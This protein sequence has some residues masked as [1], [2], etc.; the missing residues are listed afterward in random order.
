MIYLDLTVLCNREK[1]AENAYFL[2]F[3]IALYLPF[4]F[5]VNCS[6]IYCFDPWEHTHPLPITTSIFSESTL[7]ET[8]S[9]SKRQCHYSELEQ[10]RNSKKK[11]LMEKVNGHLPIP[12]TDRSH[13]KSAMF[14]PLCLIS[15]SRWTELT[16]NQVSLY[17]IMKAQEPVE[18]VFVLFWYFNYKNKII[19]LIHNS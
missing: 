8:S 1:V 13:F 9:L 2:S 14:V 3:T 7:W 15:W 11:N 16:F 4:E 10:A 12:L 19:T 6:N 17:S 5:L 18:H